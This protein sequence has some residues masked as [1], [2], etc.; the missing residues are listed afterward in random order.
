MAVYTDVSDTEIAEFMA[1]YDLGEVVSCKGI[2]EGVENSNYLIHLETGPYI[3]TLYEKRVNPDDL[4]FFISL[5]RFLAENKF[6][7]PLP[8]MDKNGQALRQLCQKPAALITFLKGLWPKKIAPYHCAALG[9][10][11]AEMHLLTAKFNQSRPNNMDLG[12]WQHLIQLS[13]P[14]ISA[15]PQDIYPAL[16]EELGFLSDHW[17]TDLPKAVIHADLFPDNV[18]FQHEHI[19][20]I[21]DYYFA[22]TDFVAYDLAIALNAWCF[23]ENHQLDT[24]KS[25]ALISAYQK[26]RPLSDAE[27][28]AFPILCRGAA[29]RFLSTRLYDWLHPVPGAI[30]SP[31]DPDEYWQKLCF[32]QQ[33]NNFATLLS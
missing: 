18:F 2:A 33:N 20:G 32:H 7:C 25:T 21:I 31:K 17:P 16:Q 13:E 5:M 27:Q 1:A 11:M 28:E 29:V 4:P 6:D 14:K 24:Q 19:S 15:Y 8:V 26:I 23:D 9:Q 3:L 30:V 22:C 12:A 10:K